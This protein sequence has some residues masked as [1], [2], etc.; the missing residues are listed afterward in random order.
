MTIEKWAIPIFTAASSFKK[1][2]VTVTKR[3]DIRCACCEIC[4]DWKGKESLAEPFEGMYVCDVCNRTIHWSCLLSLGYYKDE[5][6]QSVKKDETWACLAC[7]CL[8]NSEK[9]SRRH[10]AENEES[11]AVTWDPT[12]EPE[13]MTIHAYFEQKVHE[14]LMN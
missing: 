14:F 3:S 9:E 4:S 11:K 10:F 6:R 1:A 13:E 12:W 5:D 7:A 2:F 8:T